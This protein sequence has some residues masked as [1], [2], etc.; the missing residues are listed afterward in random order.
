MRAAVAFAIIWFASPVHGSAASGASAEALHDAIGRSDTKAVADLVA[1]YYRDAGI[2]VNEGLVWQFQPFDE[3]INWYNDFTDSILLAELPRRDQAAAYWEN[4][5]RVLTAGRWDWRSSFADDREAALLG[6]FNQFYLA[7]HEYG[8]ALTYRYDPDHLKRWDH[9]INC[10]E[11]LADRLAAA[12]LGQL[13]RE[14]GRFEELRR[15]YLALIRTINAHVAP[16]SRYGEPD[17]ATLEADCRI[18]HVAQPTAET[19]APYAS[20]FFA[21]QGALLSNRLPGLSTLYETHLLPHWRGRQPEPSVRAGVVSTVRPVPPIAIRRANRETGRNEDRPTFAPDGR[22]FLVETHMRSD[23]GGQ[24]VFGA[25][26][27]VAGSPFE[28]VL[29]MAPMADILPDLP[30]EELG[31]VLSL[32]PDRFL[33]A[34]SGGWIGHEPAWIVDFQRAGNGWSHHAAPIIAGAFVATHLLLSEDG[35]P[36]VFLLQRDTDAPDGNWVRLILDPKT[37]AV[38]ERTDTPLPLPGDPVAMGAD[39]AVYYAQGSRILVQDAGSPAAKAFAGS[40]LRGFKDAAVPL[41]AEFA[42]RPEAVGFLPAGVMQVLD[43]DPLADEHVL[44]RIEPAPENR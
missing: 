36:V 2:S 43:R 35:N 41:D 30:S 33:I 28:T 20:A 19:L 9:E 14:D 10:R 1:G 42:S 21:R 15:S 18:M 16:G 12:M 29:A 31:P 3:I 8:H 39:G 11:H 44:R 4:W 27:A 24:P 38:I 23:A 40:G 22:L 13:A 5:S 17:F 32:G 37:L 7:A 6:A 25:A 34:T 26:Y